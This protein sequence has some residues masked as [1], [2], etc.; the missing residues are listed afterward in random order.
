MVYHTIAYKPTTSHGSTAFFF[1]RVCVGGCVVS[2][3]RGGLCP[4][5]Q[6]QH[7]HRH[8][9]RH[10]QLLPS[11]RPPQ[12]ILVPTILFDKCHKQYVEYESTQDGTSTTTWP[13]GRR[14]GSTSSCPLLHPTL[15]VSKRTYQSPNVSWY[16]GQ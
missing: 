15:L 16:V 2:T 12:P 7:Q 13:T 11:S 1:G 14:R 4:N 3:D 6:G 9:H 8:Q 10:Q 5:Q